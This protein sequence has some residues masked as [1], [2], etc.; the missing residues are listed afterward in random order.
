MGW[1]GPDAAP[2]RSRIC[3]TGGARATAGCP[4]KAVAELGYVPRTPPATGIERQIAAERI[5][6]SPGPPAGEPA[7][8]RVA[9]PPFGL[10]SR[11]AARGSESPRPAAPRGAATGRG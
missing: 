6:A 5:A 1:S 3:V 2:P 9:R 10:E 8:A 11:A 4:R 7:P